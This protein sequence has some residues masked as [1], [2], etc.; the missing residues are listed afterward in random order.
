VPVA[1]FRRVSLARVGTHS[2]STGRTSITREDLQEIVRAAHDPQ[3]GRTVIKI[4]HQDP[5]FNNPAYD[6]EPVYG[7]V[8]NLCVEDDTLYGDLVNVP[9]QLAEVM[10]SAYPSRSVE[11]GYNMRTRAG[12]VFKRVLT[13]VALLGA[14]RPAIKDL[15][16]VLT[17]TAS[18]APMTYDT[19]V[20][21]SALDGDADLPQSEPG[22]PDDDPEDHERITMTDPKTPAAVLAALGL[23]EDADEEAVLARIAELNKPAD[24]PV[25]ATATV[26][27]TPPEQPVAVAAS[28]GIVL[29]PAQ[30]A[31]F[32][33]M[34]TR[35]ADLMAREEA[36]QTADAAA[37]IDGAV[38]RFSEDP[39]D[40]GRITPVTE[41]LW[42]A[43]LARDFEGTVALLSASPRLYH[44]TGAGAAVPS[45]EQTGKSSAHQRAV[46]D[47][48]ALGLRVYDN[49][50]GA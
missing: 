3:S 46:D 17:A 37:A 18:E 48:K 5:R 6:G 47:A 45:T 1:T 9:A 42:R 15:G 29:T 24:P 7:Q 49:T 23:A 43:Q 10:P 19:V 41:P 30:V 33:E 39:Q 20:L 35:L 14:T 26:P 27:G 36:R 22:T 40:G 44:S 2:A 34:E 28:E 13:A 8:E 32:S 50:K 12:R 21:M 16:D 38:R 4:G 31:T 11:I 25:A